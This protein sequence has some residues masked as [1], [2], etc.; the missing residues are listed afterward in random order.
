MLDY[1]RGINDHYGSTDLCARIVAAVRAAGLD[2]ATVTRD[3]LAPFDEFHTGGRESTREL[4]RLAGVHDG[5]LVLDVGSGIGGP[6]RTLAAEFGCR[7]TGLDLTEEFCRAAELLTGWV[8]ISDRVSF[9][10]GNA[11]HVPFDEASFDIVWS[12]NSMMNIEDK[13]ALFREVRRVLRPGGLFAFDVVAAGPVPRVRF[14]TFWAPGPA[15]NF[16]ATPDA[17]RSLL[18]EAGFRVR[19]W[20]DQT[21]AR[22]ES[23]RRRRAPSAG[24]APVLGRDVIVAEDVPLKIENSV[25]NTEEGH[26]VA[27]RAIAVR[28]A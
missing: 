6:A 19:D 15:L 14:P 21:A 4:A 9:R 5:Q 24:P 1:A 25:R 26:T 27:V 28:P 23:A 8:G 17:L 3:D 22:L 12:Q 10:H 13:A 20:Q 11:L 2:P 18:E 16:L 7:V